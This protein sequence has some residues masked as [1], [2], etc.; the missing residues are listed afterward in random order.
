M[1]KKLGVDVRM[2]TEVTKAVLDE[3]SPAAG[4]LAAG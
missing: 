4:I 3:L 2:N 1:L